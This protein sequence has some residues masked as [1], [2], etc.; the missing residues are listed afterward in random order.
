MNGYTWS[1]TGNGTIAGPANSAKVS[2]TAGSLCGGT[3]SLVLNVT[4]NSCSSA[5]SLEVL[6]AD[7]KA[8]TISAPADV[9]LE[10]PADT[11]A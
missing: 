10:C 2:V 3:F 11:R 4:S 1:I 7:T 8:P 5:A 6:V 9:T